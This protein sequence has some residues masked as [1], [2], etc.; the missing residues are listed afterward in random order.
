MLE[1]NFTRLFRAKGITTPTTYLM[2]RG[3]S[4]KFAT[5]VARNR[6]RRF[7]LGDVERLCKAFQCTP[8]D[9]LEWT[10]EK[11]D[12]DT[13]NHHLASLI[14]TE[15]VMDLSRTLNSVSFDKLLEIE[16]LIQSEIDK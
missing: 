8:N 9:L 10:P 1:F 2:N 7:N 4:D 6:Y 14:R 3:F 5:G 11:E 16:K 15:K 13:T 12:G